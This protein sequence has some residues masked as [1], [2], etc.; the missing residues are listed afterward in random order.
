MDVPN[1]KMPRVNLTGLFFSISLGVIVAVAIY[2]AQ[3]RG[4]IPAG[5]LNLPKVLPTQETRTVVNEENAVISVVEK[6]S[7]S[8]VAIG[9]SQKL[10]NPQ[11]P[12]AAPQKEDSTI[13]TGFVVTD[14]TNASSNSVQGIIVTNKHVVSFPGTYTVVTKDGQKYEVRKIYR[15]P[16]FDLAI[17][18]I[19]QNNLKAL[20][21]GDSAKL[22][23]GQSVIAIGN[24]LGKFTNTVTSGIV[25]GLGRQVM[26]GD[27]F[28]G[29][30][31]SL[32]NLIQTDAAINPGN[33]GGP[34][35]NLSG[36]VIG[37]NVAT[38]DNAQN[39]GFAIPINSVKQIVTDFM[40][41]G[42]VSR[43]YL[44]IRYK[45]ITKDLAIL[46]DVPQ[47]A[48]VS[49][50]IAGGPADKANI[51]SGDIITKINN[52]VVDSENKISDLISKANVGDTLTMEIYRGGKL[53]KV[54]ALLLESPNQ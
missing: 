38:T 50:V 37:V 30:A 8:V 2:Q 19:D 51:Q 5:N 23:V 43:P 10:L 42:F 9:I 7:P 25:S 1:M 4:L 12:F 6:T 13:G 16:N 33:S 54:K 22:K 28:E 45:F 17:L 40:V 39:I 49:D 14:P 21:L 3:L 46:N 24:A 26:A 47:G 32:N 48:F 53:T 20:T 36:E 11:D 27:P 35:L 41:K 34:L 44:G 29:S 52:M 18:Q 31:E 15:D